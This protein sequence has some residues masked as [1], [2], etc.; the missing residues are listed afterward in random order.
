MVALITFSVSAAF[1]VGLDVSDAVKPVAP[2]PPVLEPCGD[3]GQTVD[4]GCMSNN[5]QKQ[6]VYQQQLQ[7]FNFDM[8]VYNSKVQANQQAEQAA[9]A[10]KAKNE[11]LARIQATSASAS[12]NAAKQKNEESKEANQMAQMITEAISAAAMA[13]FASTPCGKIPSHCVIPFLIKS[14]LHKLLADKH[15]GQAAENAASA[16]AACS[17]GNQIT[18]SSANCG[19]Q[20]PKFIPPENPFAGISTVIDANGNCIASDKTLCDK[21]KAA[22]PPGTN[23]KDVGKTASSFASGKGFFKTNPD[24]SI[25]TKDGKTFKPSDFKDEKSLI[26]A[27]LSPGEASS[28][29]ASLSGGFGGSGL[30]GKVG[31]DLKD[32]KKPYDFSG[33]AIGGGAGFGASGLSIGGGKGGGVN[34][35][36]IGAKN[37]NGKADPRERNP[38]A[39]AGLIKEFNGEPVG[40][41]GDDLFVMMNRRYNLKNAQDSF[42]GD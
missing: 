18:S 2:T 16:F 14:I 8:Q 11:E 12:L 40:A 28:M 24:G 42:I 13:A 35:N 30:K 31:A 32:G 26:A 20:P 37:L 38:A 22:L 17:A 29:M 10:Q 9:A 21:I 5:Q 27:G 19:P 34:G 23:L 36:V 3:T 4:P 6:Q 39:A 15:G 33:M 1:A 41:A 25:T 7:K